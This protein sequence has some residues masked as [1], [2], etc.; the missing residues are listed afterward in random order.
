MG[1]V[2]AIMPLLPAFPFLLL[3]A[4]SFFTRP[5]DIVAGHFIS[6]TYCV[7]CLDRR[8]MPAY[9]DIPQ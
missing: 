8:S 9:T 2:G 1:T 3:A 5:Q 7:F 4:F 6:S